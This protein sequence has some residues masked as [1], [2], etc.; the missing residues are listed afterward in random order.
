[1]IN[2]DRWDVRNRPRPP[3]RA[4]DCETQVSRPPAIKMP[5]KAAL[6]WNTLQCNA[7]QCIVFKRKPSLESN[8]TVPYCRNPRPLGMG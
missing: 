3:V 4:S 2:S 1:M 6:A 8:C 7:L 5:A